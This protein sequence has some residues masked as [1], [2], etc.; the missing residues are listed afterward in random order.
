MICFLHLSKLTY[1]KIICSIAGISKTRFKEKSTGW[2]LKKKVSGE[3]NERV[4]V[5]EISSSELGQVSHD[6]IKLIINNILKR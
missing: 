1:M 3:R 6:F 5:S 4:L 2:F